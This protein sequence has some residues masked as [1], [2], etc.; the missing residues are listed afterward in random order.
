MEDRRQSRSSN[1]GSSETNRCVNSHPCWCCYSCYATS[2]QNKSHCRTKMT[3]F[4]STQLDTLRKQVKDEIEQSWKEAER[5]KKQ[6][7]A[8][9]KYMIQLQMKIEASK[10]RKCAGIEK[11]A[12]LKVRRMN[13]SVLVKR[14]NEESVMPSSARDCNGGNKTSGSAAFHFRGLVPS[15]LHLKTSKRLFSTQEQQARRKADNFMKLSSRDQTIIA[16]NE[17][18]IETRS[19]VKTLRRRRWSNVKR[20]LCSNG[21]KNPP[22]YIDIVLQP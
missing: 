12:R 4:L 9:M 11:I 5:L 10:A 1:D 13:T 20:R 6:C 16:L 19:T 17:V 22:R 8:K 2:E 7:A 18:L 15:L 14:S 21:I 3:D